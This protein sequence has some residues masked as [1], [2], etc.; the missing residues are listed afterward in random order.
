M[1]AYPTP[2]YRPMLI[3]HNVPCGVIASTLAYP[4]CLSSTPYHGGLTRTPVVPLAYPATIPWGL[5]QHPCISPCLSSPP[6]PRG[7]TSSNPILHRAYQAHR[8]LGAYPASPYTPPCLSSTPYHG[9]LTST[10]VPPLAYPASHTMGLNQCPMYPFLLIQP[11]L[12]WG[13]T[14]LPCTA[15]CLS[16]TTYHVRS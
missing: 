8:T 11:T 16:S 4:P 7:L 15:P 13:L 10:P 3:Q 9:G 12:P 2:L 1:G 5:N 6:Y 14:Q